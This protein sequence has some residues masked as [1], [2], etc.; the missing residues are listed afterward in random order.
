[1]G[2]GFRKLQAYLTAPAI[3]IKSAEGPKFNAKDKWD[4]AAQRQLDALFDKTSRIV[5]RK[6]GMA[7][8]SD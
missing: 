8:P 3:E 5:R 2:H 7:G 4:E 6:E 1:M